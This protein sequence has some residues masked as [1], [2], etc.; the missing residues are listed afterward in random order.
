[1]VS[2]TIGF[3]VDIVGYPPASDAPHSYLGLLPLTPCILILPVSFLAVESF[4]LSYPHDLPYFA[5][6]LQVCILRVSELLNACVSSLAYKSF[7]RAG[8]LKTPGWF[9]PASCFSFLSA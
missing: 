1:M 2:C 5:P 7:N 3:V 8:S 4:L 9:S 6:K